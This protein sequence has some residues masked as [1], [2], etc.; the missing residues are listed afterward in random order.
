MFD[1]DENE[2]YE[3]TKH[4]AYLHMT[5]SAIKAGHIKYAE[6]LRNKQHLSDHD[7]LYQLA[8]Q[9]ANRRYF[10]YADFLRHLEL[11]SSRDLIRVAAGAVI[12]YQ[13]NYLTK[14]QILYLLKNYSSGWTLEQTQREIENRA[15]LWRDQAWPSLLS[16]PAPRIDCPETLNKASDV[17]VLA[18]LPLHI[19]IEEAS[20]LLTS[21]LWGSFVLLA[22]LSNGYIR[23]KIE[24]TNNFLNFPVWLRILEFIFGENINIGTPRVVRDIWTCTRLSMLGN[25]FTNMM[26]PS[27][28]LDNELDCSLPRRRARGE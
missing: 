6:Q 15:V 23:S 21:G 4:Y 19:T 5:E 8:A 20:T 28:I 12:G 2:D 25:F 14:M 16:P 17:I 24:S 3:A 9:A 1:E 27:K 22:N 7:S 10:E 26:R 18:R 13:L 11:Q